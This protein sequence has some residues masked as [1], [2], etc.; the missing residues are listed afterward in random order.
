MAATLGVGTWHYA[1]YALFSFMS[2][3]VVLALAFLNIRMGKALLPLAWCY[4]SK[5]M[6][7][8]EEAAWRQ[9]EKRGQGDEWLKDRWTRRTAKP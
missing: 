3:L 7:P 9:A 6:P 8:E 5:R 2:P 1:P 4:V